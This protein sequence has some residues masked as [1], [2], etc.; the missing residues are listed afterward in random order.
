MTVKERI[1]TIRLSERILNH[2]EFA[3]RIGVEVTIVRHEGGVRKQAVGKSK[4]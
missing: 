1:A 4:V 2:Q 3:K